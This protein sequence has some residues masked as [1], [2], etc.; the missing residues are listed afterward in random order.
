ML[1]G[2]LLLIFGVSVAEEL[3]QVLR[4]R[5]ET[6]ASGVGEAAVRGGVPAVAVTRPCHVEAEA[7]LPP[8]S[9]RGRPLLNT[10]VLAC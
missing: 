7:Q 5:E 6:S 2:G 9:V 8:S 4:K 10:K 3:H 1:P